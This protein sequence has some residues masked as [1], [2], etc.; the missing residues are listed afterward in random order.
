MGLNLQGMASGSN[1]GPRGQWSCIQHGD[2]TVPHVLGC[3]PQPTCPDSGTA[4]DA[5]RVVA[6]A[7]ADHL[8]LYRMR[9]PLRDDDVQVLTVGASSWCVRSSFAPSSFSFHPAPVI[10]AGLGMAV[11]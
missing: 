10:T 4:N 5:I 3:M 11:S 8:P 2:L 1:R 9:I 7:V 6:G